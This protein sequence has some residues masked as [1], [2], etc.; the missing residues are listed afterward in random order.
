MCWKH[1]FIVWALMGP[2]PFAIMWIDIKYD[3]WSRWAAVGFGAWTARSCVS[4]VA[5]GW[6]ALNV[7]LWLRPC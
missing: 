7:T 6:I 3:G 5:L 4:I 2:F 1:P